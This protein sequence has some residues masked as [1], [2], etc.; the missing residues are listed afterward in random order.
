MSIKIKEFLR[1]HKPERAVFGISVGTSL[2]WA[3]MGKN[4]D[5]WTYSSSKFLPLAREDDFPA[6][7]IL[8][9]KELTSLLSLTDKID[10]IAIRLPKFKWN[11]PESNLRV[12]ICFGM[13]K[14]F[15]DI[16]EID[17][18]I[19]E[20]G[21]VTPEIRDA[22]QETFLETNKH[23]I[24]PLPFISIG[25]DEKAALETLFAV[26]LVPEDEDE[27]DQPLFPLQRGM[28]TRR[29]AGAA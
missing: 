2:G 17:H 13:V 18:T 4:G 20:E 28:V 22:A 1:D 9:K 24:K 10:A 12:M 8:L 29:Q 16:H 19:I 21:D 6:Q 7:I 15:C 5:F 3:M 11:T 14:A 23:S 27:E 25:M 26:V